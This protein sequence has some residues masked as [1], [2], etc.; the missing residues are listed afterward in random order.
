M[1]ACKAALDVPK[2]ADNEDEMPTGG[3]VGLNNSHN[4]S[5]A[6]RAT[7]IAI[8]NDSDIEEQFAYKKALIDSN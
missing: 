6:P 3:V 7:T 2:H 4:S 5:R 1:I 8:D